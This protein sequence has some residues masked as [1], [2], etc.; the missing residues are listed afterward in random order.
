MKCQPQN[1]TREFIKHFTPLVVADEIDTNINTK[2]APGFDGISPRILKELPKKA[3]IHLTNI[4]NAVLRTEFVP[5]QWK[6]AEV[7]M[8]LKPGKPPEQASSYQPISLLPCMSKLFE[9]L[10]LKH[11]KPIIEAK[12]L[13]T[14]FD[15]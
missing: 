8:L 5:E 12:Q 10:L 13:T 14:S 1:S 2:K 4:Y 9:K 3:I 11:L 7:I 15:F 6:R